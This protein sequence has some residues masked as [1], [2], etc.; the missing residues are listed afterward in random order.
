MKQ[1]EQQIANS[2]LV[3]DEQTEWNQGK[4]QFHLRSHGCNE[5]TCFEHTPSKLFSGCHRPT[6]FLHASSS[7]SQLTSPSFSVAVVPCQ[8]TWGPAAESRLWTNTEDFG[9]TV[10]PKNV[11]TL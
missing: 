4:P 8:R 1:L 6:T 2:L 10:A 9:A 11:C 5:T 3:L 7:L